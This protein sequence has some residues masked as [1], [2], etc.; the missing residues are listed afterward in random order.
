MEW[1]LTRKPRAHRVTGLQRIGVMIVVGLLV[2]FAYEILL[3][4]F[5]VSEM[6]VSVFGWAMGIM[7][8]AVAAGLFANSIKT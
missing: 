8:V 7:G 2:F 4:A 1:S 5:G 3:S 6:D